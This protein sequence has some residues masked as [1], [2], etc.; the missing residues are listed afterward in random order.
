MTM[1][2]SGYKIIRKPVERIFMLYF[3]VGGSVTTTGSVPDGAVF[4]FTQTL[5]YR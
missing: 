1:L 2:F 4:G 3:G 5:A